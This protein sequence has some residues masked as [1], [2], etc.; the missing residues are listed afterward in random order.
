MDD[1]GMGVRP[2]PAVPEILCLAEAG[3][4]GTVPNIALRDIPD[5]W[6]TGAVSQFVR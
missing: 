3:A 2:S 5:V 1:S 4:I 6:W